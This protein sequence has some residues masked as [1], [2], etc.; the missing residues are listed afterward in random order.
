MSDV[1]GQ[2]DAAL[3]R[4]AELERERDV[5]IDAAF[6]EHRRNVAR[7]I[8]SGAGIAIT[9]E[10]CPHGKAIGRFDSCRIC[11]F[12][13]QQAERANPSPMRRRAFTLFAR[14]SNHIIE[15]KAA[16]DRA[17]SLL[18]EWLPRGDVFGECDECGAM[19]SDPHKPDCEA[20]AEIRRAISM[21][22][23]R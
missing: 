6:E 10:V 19:R 7:F 23:P 9:D 15:L 22:V 3:A 11:Y 14:M 12:K 17:H 20:V 13:A 21:D 1:A 4:V 16:L 8:T 2:R 18:L 5:A